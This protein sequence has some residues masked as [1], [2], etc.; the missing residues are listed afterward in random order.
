MSDNKDKAS[1]IES[2]TDEKVKD[3]NGIGKGYLR[4]GNSTATKDK[5][6]SEFMSNGTPIM[7]L[8]GEFRA[9]HG[10]DEKKVDPV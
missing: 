6:S 5:Q 9:M 7:D 10:P 1:K 4:A 8:L 2:L 3:E